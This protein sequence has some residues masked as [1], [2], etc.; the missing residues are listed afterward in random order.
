MAKKKTSLIIS[1]LF[2]ISVFSISILYI[3]WPK[4]EFSETEKRYL[5]SFPSFSF[6]S[7]KSGRFA[8]DFEKFLSDQTPFRKFF[9]SLSA[10]FEL[11]EGNNGSNGVYLGKNG[12]L[13]EKP[14]DRVNNFD[15]NLAEI[16][17]FSSAAGVP[18]YLLAVPEKGY[19]CSSCLP[20]NSLEYEDDAYFK[21][22]SEGLDGSIKFIDVRDALKAN[23]L[24]S[25]YKTDHHW[26]GRGAYAAYTEFCKSLGIAAA[27]EK[28][29]EVTSYPGFYG[30]SYSTSCYT[31]TKPD[32]ISLWRSKS[33]ASCSVK[34]TEG[35]KV[36]ENRGVFFDANLDKSDMYTAFL[37][38]NHSLV[39]IDTGSGGKTLLLIKDSFA[40][41]FVP[42]ITGNYGRIIMID[43]RYYKSSVK[44]L[45]AEEKA[46]EILFLYGLEN[47]AES[48][49][50]YLD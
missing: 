20:S 4:Y 39:D 35:S 16:N 8:S 34:I 22:L 28:D 3:F 50:I 1:V 10:Y 12:F 33:N 47:L 19:I 2:L 14:F 41:S 13:I 32:E 31:F 43:L 9:V 5:S 27:P 29:F 42:L 49:D 26:A 7:V 30:T 40:H 38:G 44:A 24:D 17:R 36:T 46:D 15:R 21:K 6:E 18:V 11:F 25:F 37:D 48:K 23:A 45:A